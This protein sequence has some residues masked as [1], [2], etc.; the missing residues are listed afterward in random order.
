MW[1]KVCNSQEEPW[2]GG[3]G[4]GEFVVHVAVDTHYRHTPIL[5]GIQVSAISF[6]TKKFESQDR[7]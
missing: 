5:C 6:S 4:G 2:G 7:L 1:G 3:G